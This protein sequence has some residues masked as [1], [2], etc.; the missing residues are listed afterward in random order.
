MAIAEDIW[1]IRGYLGRDIWDRDIWDI[2]EVL[3]IWTG[4]G[5]PKK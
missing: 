5:T 1:D 4:S 3:G 2:H